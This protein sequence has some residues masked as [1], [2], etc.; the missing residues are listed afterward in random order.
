L[1]SFGKNQIV[2]LLETA[3]L[4]EEN[5]MQRGSLGQCAG[6]II[7]NIPNYEN[8]LSDIILH[9][10][11]KEEIRLTAIVLAREF[12]MK[13][14]VA[15]I[16]Y[17]FD[18]TDWGNIRDWLKEWVE[19]YAEFVDTPVISIIEK[20]VDNASYNDDEIAYALRDIGTP[21]LVMNEY[22]IRKIEDN[23]QNPTVRFYAQRAIHR[24][25]RYKGQVNQDLLPGFETV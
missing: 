3:W 9:S 17:E 22:L 10:G 24:I 13:M 4:D 14:I 6:V 11:F 7:I 19:F 15:K 2:N 16:V 18:K 1:N 8:H 21:A 12:G 25:M 5:L 20:A 23:T